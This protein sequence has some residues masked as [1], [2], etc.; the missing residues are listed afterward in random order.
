[1]YKRLLIVSLIILTSLCGL[2]ALGYYSIGLHAEGLA[3]RRANEFVAVAEQ[4][5]LDVARRLDTFIKAEQNR[6]YTD[7][8]YSYVPFATNDASAIVRSPLAGSISAGLAY[9]YFQ[10]DP[11]GTIISPDN[12]PNQQPS[13]PLARA[14]LENVALNL[15]PALSGNGNSTT[16][17]PEAVPDIAR[18]QIARRA[19]GDAQTRLDSLNESKRQ[20]T[21]SPAD[22]S[23]S[24]SK[25]YQQ[26]RR[27]DYR[28]QTFEQF[29]DQQAKV[30]TQSRDNV[31]RNIYNSMAQTDAYDERQYSQ[32]ASAQ[33]QAPPDFNTQSPS[34][35]QGVQIQQGAPGPQPVSQQETVQVRIE[36]FVPVVVPAPGEQTA[37][38][39]QV[40]LLRHV[41]IEQRHF[42][43]GFRLNES[44]LIKQIGESASRHILGRDM[45]CDIGAAESPQAV[46][47]ATLDFGFGELIL[48]LFELKPALIANQVSSLKTAYFAIVTVVFLAVALAQGSLWRTA[49][50]Q[51]NLARKK[52]DFISAVSHELRTPLTTIRMH[53]E[54]LEKGWVTSE[55]KRREYYATMTQET[56]RLTRLIENVLDFSRIQ[57]GRK[58]YNFTLGD[59]NRCI[60][61]VVSMMTPFAAQSGFTI[62]K[63]LAELPQFAFDRDAVMQIVINLLDNA[64]KYAGSAADKTIGVRTRSDNG[65][66][67][68]EVE[69]H[70]PGVPRLQRQK[71]FEEFYRCQDESR[72]E[73]TGTGLGLALVRRFA[74]AHNGFVDILAAQPTGAIF[75]VALAPQR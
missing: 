43:Q 27:N 36:P 50:Q 56:E 23:A 35:Q 41:Q 59:I 10:I 17:R 21:Q 13:S 54:M 64:V 47:T 52:D 37:F 5:R 75:R 62:E 48:N 33:R 20:E 69:D 12:M 28:I 3:A 60:C 55:E 9:G 4:I 34:A 26:S 38:P 40:F 29:E 66:I 46:H 61:D 1:M 74:Q 45:G 72:R 63:D 18:S 68:L 57:R 42:L 31:E 44:E 25:G 39:G 22:A 11:D 16:I 15:L 67:L 51:I 30:L 7:Y 2:C 24:K 53:T 58:K 32:K 65:Y 70:G 19:Q 8:Q 73:A 71:V 6:P 14:H 49:R